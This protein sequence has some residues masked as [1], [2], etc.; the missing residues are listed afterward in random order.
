MTQ[1]YP[2]PSCVHIFET[3]CHLNHLQFS[4]D[5]EEVLARARGVGVSELALIG[6]DLESSRRAVEMADP[7]KGL[8]ATAGIHPHDAEIWS[9]CA[10]AELR[11]LAR[12]AGTVAIGEI[13]LDFYRDL[14]PREAQYA[15]FRAQ[16]DLAAELNLPIVV[17]TRESVTPSLD[18]IEPYAR[19][20]LRG[21]M[22]C[23]SGTLAE[24]RR[25]RSLGLL[26]GVGGVIT[27]KKPGEL[28]EVVLDTPLEGL[29]LETD[30]P[31]LPPVPHRG[32]RNEPSHLPLIATK[33]AEIKGLTASQ[34]ASTTRSSAIA[35]FRLPVGDGDSH[36]GT[37]STEGKV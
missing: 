1:E 17:H 8:Y 19:A 15:A 27:Y 28:P 12:A 34:V 7:E 6:Y 23:W 20:G 18:A 16:L 10:E 37:E 22:H 31:Y 2:G 13:G 29:V 36:R 3:H 21:I 11:R 14:S 25:A 30:S 5:L 32:K 9:A 33:V 4:H 35:F 26:L 24:A